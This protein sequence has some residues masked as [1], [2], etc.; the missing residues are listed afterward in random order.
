M[1]YLLRHIL[2]LLLLLSKA[3]LYAQSSISTE[4]LI[5]GGGTGGIAAGI[6]SARMGI[7]TTI[8]ESTTM[9]GGMLTAAG[10]SC[11]DGNDSLPSGIWQ[12]F[13]Q[14]LYKHYGTHNLASGWV[15]ETCFE[16]HVGDSIFKS[17]AA[18]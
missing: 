18:N 4:I 5:V 2:F 7:H 1:G 8:I 3:T 17:W 15:S 6:Q 16:P 14:A 11:T 12:E 9:L 13:R 10:V